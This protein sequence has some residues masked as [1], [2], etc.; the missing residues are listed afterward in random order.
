MSDRGRAVKAVVFLLGAFL[1][2]LFIGMQLGN[3]AF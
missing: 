3:K 1:V 2:S